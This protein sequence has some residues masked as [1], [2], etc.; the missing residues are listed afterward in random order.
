MPSQEYVEERT[1]AILNSIRIYSS[2]AAA[3]ADVD[4]GYIEDGNFCYARTESDASIASEL[5]NEAGV[6]VA[7]GRVIPAKTAIDDAIAPYSPLLP[8]TKTSE[9]FETGVSGNE[10]E[11]VT[12]EDITF[13]ENKN[14][15][16]SIRD[17]K[18]M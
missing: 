3:Q 9:F 2:Q 11:S 6:L 17:G 7:T 15:L 16:R 13:D 4:A 12:D 14:I 5:Q 18:Q 10:Y 1:G 8:L